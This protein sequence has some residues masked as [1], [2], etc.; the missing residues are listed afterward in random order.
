M[1]VLE[2]RAEIVAETALM[3]GCASLSQLERRDGGG[4]LEYPGA[5]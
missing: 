2:A 4:R 5:A 1:T 3:H